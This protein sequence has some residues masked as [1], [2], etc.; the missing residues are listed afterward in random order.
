MFENLLNNSIFGKIAP[1]LCRLTANG[2][3]AVRTSDGN[4]KSYNVETGRLTNQSNFVFNIGDDFFFAIPTN[5]VKKGDIILVN[6]KPN[7]VV[8]VSADKNKIE[9]VNFE[10]GTLDTIIPER[11]VFMG[12]TYFYGKIVSLFGS[13]FK[14]KSGSNNMFKTIMQ[15]QFMQS[16]MGSKT[17]DSN[18]SNGGMMQT[19]MM[20]SMMN[21]GGMGDLFGDMFD[22]D[23]NEEEDDK[24]DDEGVE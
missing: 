14:S 3:V 13:K 1:G 11:H 24:N 4:Y 12:N 16:M 21:G 19:M 9:V 15:M 23:D 22:F 6:G 17:T 5:K 2:Q 7:C 20:M 18:S 10:T 8:S